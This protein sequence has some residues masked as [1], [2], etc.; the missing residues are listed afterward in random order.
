MEARL[1]PAW[2]LAG[3]GL[4]LVALLLAPK[5]RHTAPYLPSPSEVLEKA[6]PVRAREVKNLAEATAAAREL[7]IASRRAG[8]DPRLLGRAQ[9]V[10]GPWWSSDEVPAEVRV[11]RATIRQSFHDFPA[12]LI[13]LDAV[14]AEHP[15]DSQ[16]WLTRATVLQVLSR[17]DEAEASCAHLTGVSIVVST[18]CHA[19]IE[20]LRG[21]AAHARDA[22]ASA[23]RRASAD[24]RPWAWSILGDL[25]AWAGDAEGAVR[26]YREVLELDSGDEYT[27]GA[28]ADL[29]LDLG[30]PA[31]VVMLLQDHTQN[32][33]Q[34]LR[35]AI[36]AKRSG[37]VRAQ[38]WA[39]LIAERVEAGRARQDVVHRR[40]EARYAL[41]IEG[42]FAKALSLAQANFQVQKEPAD[43]RILLEAALAVKQH[44]AAA[45]A[46]AW[47]SATGFEEPTIRALAA[48][49]T[50]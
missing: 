15:D 27:R 10:L 11:L 49:V 47:L 26:T 25:T 14:V 20:G 31:D 23:A 6:S 39:T 16:A 42:D 48:K 5:E 50:R 41:E 17:L 9:A 13:D 30:R 7:I 24:E 8:G 46:L 28:L 37:H 4:A 12:A 38:E 32:D 33:A 43:A 35:L 19:Q 45:A 34:V 3:T 1:K 40:E 44:D 2:V 29:L 21:H 22:L 36:A 18:V